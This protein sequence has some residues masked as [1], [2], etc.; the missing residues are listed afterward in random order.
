MRKLA[1]TILALALLVLSAVPAFGATI[2][3]GKLKE[4]KELN[5]QIYTLK[6]KMIETKVEAGILEK[7]KADKIMNALQER[8]KIMEQDFEKGE[9]H[10]FGHKKGCS[11]NPSN[12][13]NTK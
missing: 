10:D 2:D 4:L 7:G 9:Y 1:A 3:Q 13:K 8:Q 5:Q 12:A 11:R 6:T